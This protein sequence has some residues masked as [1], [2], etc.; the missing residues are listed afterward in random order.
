MRPIGQSVVVFAFVLVSGCAAG[1]APERNTGAGSPQSS[2]GSFSPSFW[3]MASPPPSG[4]GTGDTTDDGAAAP[5]TDSGALQNP[6]AGDDSTSPVATDDAEAAAPA[7]GLGV[8]FPAPPEAGMAASA[9]AATCSNLGCFDIFD[10]AIY[11]PAE[12]GP[13]GFTQCVNFICK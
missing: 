1:S 12:F 13:C 3:T 5:G 6:D 10:C 9:D 8:L 4:T 2:G 11:H 7:P